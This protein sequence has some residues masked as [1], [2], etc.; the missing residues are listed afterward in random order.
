MDSQFPP[1]YPGGLRIGEEERAAVG[2][3]LAARRPFRYY[4][5]VDSP[6]AVAALEEDFA[7]R[8]GVAHAVAVASGTSALTAAL[9]ALG[10]GPGDQVLVPAYTWIS[11]PAAVLAV[12]AVPVIVDVDET[13]SIDV[14]YARLQLTEST[15]AILPV[16]MRG[17][18]ADM[19]RVCAFAREH[20]LAVLEDVAQSAGGSYDGR[21]LGSIGDMGIFSLQFNKVITS[22]EGG[23]IVTDDLELHRRALQYQDVAAYQ[24]L[25]MPA[26]TP[27]VAT[28][29]RM[30]ELQGALARVQ[31][32][33]LDSIIA[34][35][36]RNR[37]LLLDHLGGADGLG[38]VVIRPSNDPA[39]DLGIALVLTFPDVG[40]ATAVADHVAAAG[41]PCGLLYQPELTNFHVACD[42]GPILGQRSWSRTTPWDLQRD[43]VTYDPSRWSRAV[44]LLG[45][46]M[47]IHVSP[48]LREQQVGTIAAVVRAALA[49]ADV[50]ITSERPERV[51]THGD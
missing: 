50:H 6:S 37:D 43:P 3:V 13:L 12:G 22:G 2:A 14:D 36:R 32:K 11:T 9:A 18:P 1:M 45:R 21:P 34:D 26:Q 46:S 15:R 10:V 16:H 4:G 29:C 51:T 44:D 49:R 41:I 40:R 28:T 23:V 47:Q 5:A 17:A 25:G 33:R 19:S 8:V 24:R 42:W 31:L 38:D 7:Q 39:G 27:F 30:S 20:G 35:C 48:D